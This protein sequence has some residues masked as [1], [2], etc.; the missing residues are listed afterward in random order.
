M[1]ATVGWQLLGVIVA[2]LT[3]ACGG[4]GTTGLEPANTGD[5]Q[6]T[7]ERGP[8][9]SVPSEASSAFV[10]VWNPDTDFNLV[11]KVE[12]PDPGSSTRV[13]FTVPSGGG[14]LA[15]VIAKE[16]GVGLAAGKSSTFSVG[17]DATTEVQ[18]EVTPWDIAL[19]QA[20]DAVVSGDTVTLK[21]EISGAPVGG[22]LA[23]RFGA[24][25]CW[26]TVPSISPCSV[27]TT[28]GGDLSGNQADI[29]FNVPNIEDAD[30]FYFHFVFG[31]DGREGWEPS[32]NV[33]AKV[34]LP[35]TTLGDTVFSLPVESASGKVQVIFD[36]EGE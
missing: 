6:F 4:G 5:V 3:L 8:Q 17:P 18:V 13:N 24:T 30:R 1:R 23:R 36:Q 33:A 21:A 7:L 32:S 16:S 31:V 29:T 10:R 12:V 19:T 2:M 35:E 27:G 28:P 25:L 14:Y 15:G 26:D 20:P 11:Q 22:Y 34:N 9:S